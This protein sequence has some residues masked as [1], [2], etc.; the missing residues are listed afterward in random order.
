M[1]LKIKTIATILL[2][3]LIAMCVLPTIA[4]TPDTVP[5][6]VAVTPVISISVPETL[7][8]FGTPRPGTTVDPITVVITNDGDVNVPVEATISGT[9]FIDIL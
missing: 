5:L 4:G 8:D 2:A 3:V 7:V 9:F 1:R 6:T